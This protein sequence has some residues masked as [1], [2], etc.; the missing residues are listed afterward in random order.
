MLKIKKNKEK[1]IDSL[2]GKLQNILTIIDNVEMATMNA[3][4]YETMKDGSELLKKLNAETPL[5]QILELLDDL[6]DQYKQTEEVTSLLSKSLLGESDESTILE[7]IEQLRSVNNVTI[8]S[9]TATSTD[10]AAAVL[11][12]PIIFPI[13]PTTTPVIST[14]D[15][16]MHTDTTASASSRNNNTAIMS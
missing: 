13:V 14:V 2:D 9:S 12:T 10:T 7:E 11:P 15:D 1:V 3:Q 4:V 5:D 6:D 8:A 16:T